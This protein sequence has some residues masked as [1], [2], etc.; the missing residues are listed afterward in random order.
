MSTKNIVIPWFLIAFGSYCFNTT[1]V[2]SSRFIFAHGLKVL[3]L[4]SSWKSFRV[5]RSQKICSDKMEMEMFPEHAGFELVG[6]LKYVLSGRL[7]MK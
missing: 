2:R 4:Y 6:Y 1:L 5:S 3:F 7:H